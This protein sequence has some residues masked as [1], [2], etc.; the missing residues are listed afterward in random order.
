MPYEPKRGFIVAHKGNIFRGAQF[1]TPLSQ[2][3]SCSEY[4]SHLC[5]RFAETFGDEENGF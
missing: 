4:I 2:G 3:G 1:H 5:P